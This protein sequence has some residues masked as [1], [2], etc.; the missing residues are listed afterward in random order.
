MTGIEGATGIMP[1]T[2]PA[3]ADMDDPPVAPTES[4]DRPA[5][6]TA[7]SIRERPGRLR[8]AARISGLLVVGMLAVLFVIFRP[9]TLGGS[10]LYVFVQGHS[11][12]PT[13]H[14][15]DLAVVIPAES[16]AVGDIV[17]YHPKDV[18]N[19]AIIHRIVGGDAT[20]GFIIQGDNRTSRDAD[21]PRA[22][23]LI[24]RAV[25]TAPGIAW[26]LEAL[27]DPLVFGSLG[28]L[29]AVVL[30]L[31]YVPAFRRKG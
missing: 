7:T 11:M 2:G 21:R 19:G 26:V 22:D 15:G 27:R 1:V 10:T 12:E 17:A 9:T 25:A 6:S 20:A 8:R 18:P 29:V 28:A 4:G 16:Y 14:T 31:E 30:A 13:L 5:A 23:Q 24:G 3:Q